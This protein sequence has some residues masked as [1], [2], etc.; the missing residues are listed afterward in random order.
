ML[1][2]TLGHANLSISQASLIGTR[3][4]V[5]EP[6]CMIKDNETN[7]VAHQST[8]TYT[9]I[10]NILIIPSTDLSEKNNNNTNTKIAKIVH[11]KYRML[12]MDMVKL[13]HANQTLH[14]EG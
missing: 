5:P 6:A 3:I 4:L 11:V 10:T 7:L 13:K 8:Y 14:E 1:L 12:T 9:S 2:Q